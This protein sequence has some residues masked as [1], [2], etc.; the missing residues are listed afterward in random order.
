LADCEKVRVDL[1]KNAA[2]TRLQV[3]ELDQELKEVREAAAV[4]RRS[5]RMSSLRRGARPRRPMHNLML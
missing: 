3:A 2:A 5:L 4:E 1:L